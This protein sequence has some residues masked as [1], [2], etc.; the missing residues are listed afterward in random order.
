MTKKKILILL[1]DKSNETSDGYKSY[2]GLSQ[3]GPDEYSA[4]RYRELVFEISPADLRI[5]FVRE[6]QEI[7]V[8]SFDLVYIRDFQGYEPERNCVAQ[9]LIA[10]QK[11]FLN[12]DVGSSQRLSKTAQ[13]IQFHIS[14]VPF[15]RSV[16]CALD[17]AGVQ[18]ARCFGGYPVIVKGIQSRSGG[19]NFLVRSPEEMADIVKQYPGAKMV[20]QEFI[21]NDGDYRY[22]VLGDQVTCVYKRTRVAGDEHRNNVSVGGNKEY[23]DLETIPAELKALAVRAAACLSREICGIDIML[24]SETA[25]PVVLEANFN[26]GVKYVDQVPQELYGL[27]EYLHQSASDAS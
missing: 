17:Q 6:D 2:L 23:Q 11:K 7:D 27:A 25:E 4:V 21:P 10:K 26:F 20:I 3:I 22:I 19:E 18:I 5:F 15:P 8:A 9:Y 1:G 14:H 16:Y 24:N 13:Y 12:S